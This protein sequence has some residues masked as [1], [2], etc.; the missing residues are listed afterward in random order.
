MKFGFRHADKF[1]GLFILVAVVFLSSS[2]VVTS[3]NR[4]WFAR[5]YE[6]FS[7]FFSANGLSVGMP[8][9]LRG[10]E[11]G[12]IKSFTLNSDNKVDVT[13]VIYDTYIEKVT[14]GSVL[15]LATN[16]LG[17]GGGL[18]FYPGI[19]NDDALVEFSYIPSNQSKEGKAL[20]A[21][22]KVDKP[23]G[24]DAINAIMENINP[25]LLGV[26]NMIASM[27]GIMD[28]VES[29]L[30]GNQATPLG[31]MLVNLEDTT[32]ELNTILPAVE[33]ILREVE[34]MT[35]S[36]S[37]LMVELEDPTG[38]I[39]TLLDPSGSLETI[40]NDDNELYGHLIGILVEIQ[41]NLENLSSMTND[42]K[43]ITPELNMVLDETSSAIQE[44]KKVLEGLSNNPL[45]R[46]G[47]SEEA[48]A[49]YQHGTLRDEEF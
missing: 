42:L 11:I 24:E 34:K 17:L 14:E 46:K 5:D 12:K 22:D 39:P 3:I 38:L 32:S 1:V 47:I 13:L 26:D 25:I 21:S 37:T 15:E 23:G 20:L 7:R 19:V 49:D 27:T 2:L 43:G 36:L 44:G 10:F 45:L 18:N 41:T 48:S 29:A 40:L 35:H 30:A 33:A 4:R 6:Y 9:K 28:Q 31:G 8:L 16:P